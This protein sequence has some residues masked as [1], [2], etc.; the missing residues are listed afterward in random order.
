MILKQG[1]ISNTAVLQLFPLSSLNLSLHFSSSIA[2]VV[3]LKAKVY[4]EISRREEHMKSR[5]QPALHV[6]DYL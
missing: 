2:E 3:L 1:I 6:F 4:K 5:P